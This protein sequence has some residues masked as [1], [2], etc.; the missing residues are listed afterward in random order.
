MA[1]PKTVAICDSCW[2]KYWHGR[3]PYRVRSR[4][5]ETCDFC[6]QTTHSGI[7][8]RRKKDALRMGEALRMPESPCTSC[9]KI[10]DAAN[11]I[12]ED[13]A[14]KPDPGDAT[15]CLMCGH[16]MVFDDNL[17]LRDPTAAEQE[18]FAGDKRLLTIQEA[19]GRVMKDKTNE[20][21]DR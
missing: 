5:E 15:V 19:R 13:G 21:P 1:S 9:G 11:A 7:Y 20:N 14:G 2:D 18:N 3:V 4:P 8:V 17:R 6:K 12:S 16:I 10:L